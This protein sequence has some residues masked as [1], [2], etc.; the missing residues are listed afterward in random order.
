MIVETGAPVE[1]LSKLGFCK[2]RVSLINSGRRIATK[3]PNITRRAIEELG[4]KDIQVIEREGALEA[5]IRQ[6]IADAIVDQVATGRTISNCGLYEN[7]VIMESQFVLAANKKS[8][9]GMKEKIEGIKSVID[10]VLSAKNKNLVIFNISSKN[11]EQVLSFVP[12]CKS[13]TISSLADGK[14]VAVSTVVPDE[15]LRTTIT[16]IRNKGGQNILVQPISMYI[17]DPQPRKQTIEDL[18]KRILNRKENPVLFSRTTRYLRNENKLADK[19]LEECGE[20]TEAAKRGQKEGKDGIIWEAADTLYFFLTM[21]AASS[22][23]VFGTK[24]NVDLKTETDLEGMGLTFLDISSQVAELFKRRYTIV[25]GDD[26]CPE[27]WIE[28]PK[29]RRKLER[30]LNDWMSLWRSLLKEKG[31]SEEDIELENGRRDKE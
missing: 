12:S 16:A 18:Y 3:L 2:C 1:I 27:G 17:N 25:G 13:P 11:V 8:L 7:T 5:A 29:N 10:G 14:W 23:D 30:C 24:I 26:D 15:L 4:L 6:G 9:Q 22:D 19:F 31:I 28:T 21:L 20:L